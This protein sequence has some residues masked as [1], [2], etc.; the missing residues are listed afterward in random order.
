MT[1]KAPVVRMIIG[2]ISLVNIELDWSKIVWFGLDWSKMVEFGLVFTA[3]IAEHCPHDPPDYLPLL[4]AVCSSSPHLT[5]LRLTSPLPPPPCNCGQISSLYC[6]THGGHA[7]RWTLLNVLLW[8]SSQCIACLAYTGSHASWRG[9][10]VKRYN[11]RA[12]QAAFFAPR[13]T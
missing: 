1:T 5:N 7:I 4:Q 6:R 10:S 11:A 9:S 8:L 12:S 2:L 3:C 13:P